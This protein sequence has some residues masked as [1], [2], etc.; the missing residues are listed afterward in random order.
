MHQ[1]YFIIFCNLKDLR[2]SS[3]GIGKDLGGFWRAVGD[4]CQTK[5][6]VFMVEKGL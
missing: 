6:A 1:D 2:Q 5:I 4:L 3:F